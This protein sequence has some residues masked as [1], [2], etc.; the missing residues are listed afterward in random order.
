MSAQF[1]DD[2]AGNCF[3]YR[4]SR[5]VSSCLIVR[6]YLD[7]DLGFF[8]FVFF[9]CAGVNHGTGYDKKTLARLSWRRVLS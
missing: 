8:L 6:V 2:V 4:S 3:E 7:V 9:T 5:S 1:R